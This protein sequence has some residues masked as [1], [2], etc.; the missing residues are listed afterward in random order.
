MKIQWQGTGLR[1]IH[2]YTFQPGQIVE[3]PDDEVALDILTQPNEPF[4]EIKVEVE[5][6]RTRRSRKGA[7]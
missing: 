7:E 5:P 1:I 2:G 4:I 3:I 6:A